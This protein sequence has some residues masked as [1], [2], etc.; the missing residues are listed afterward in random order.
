GEL[1]AAQIAG[2]LGAMGPHRLGPEELAGFVEGMRAKALTVR[3][4]RD[5]LIDNCGTGG[6]GLGTFNFST[7][8]ALV[9]AGAGVAVAKHGNR[10]VS[11]RSGSADVLEA[12]G[13]AVDLEPE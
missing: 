11:S 1:D 9:V 12:L 5:P 7:A 10:A 4:A 13:V 2:F 8:A 3:V 6:D